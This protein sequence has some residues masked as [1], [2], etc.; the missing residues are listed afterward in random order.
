MEN[1]YGDYETHKSYEFLECG[2]GWGFK[3]AR[4]NGGEAANHASKK[5][6]FREEAMP[7][8]QVMPDD[9]GIFWS[10]VSFRDKVIEFG[11]RGGMSG[12]DF[13]AEDISLEVEDV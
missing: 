3:G 12:D 8:L 13:V 9:K 11:G 10:G 4:L 5:V 7:G 1:I 2:D 6:W